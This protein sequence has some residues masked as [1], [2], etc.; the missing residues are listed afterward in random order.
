[1]TIWHHL[2]FKNKQTLTTHWHYNSYKLQ[3]LT[4]RNY[5]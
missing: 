3:G 5:L 2:E 1:M 4:N